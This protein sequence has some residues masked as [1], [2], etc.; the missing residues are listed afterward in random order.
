MTSWVAVVILVVAVAS[1]PIEARLW[2]AGR[3]SDRT[4]TL[5]LLARMPM[6]VLSF[7]ILYGG[8]VPITLLLLAVSFLPMAVFYRFVRNLLVEQRIEQEKAA[9]AFSR[10]PRARR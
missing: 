10:T 7:S 8:N 2:R 9:A 4:T 5:L 3:L 6:L 1:R